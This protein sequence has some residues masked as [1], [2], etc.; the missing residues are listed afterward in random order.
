MMENQKR[1][2]STIQSTMAGTLWARAKYSKLYPDILSD[3]R[4]SELIEKVMKSYPDSEDEF[5]ILEEFIDELLGLAFIVRARTFDDAVREFIDG[6]PLASI[7]NLGC[8]L[9]TT[10]SRVDNGQIH[11]YDLDLPDAIEYRLGLIP[12]TDRSRCIPKSIFDYSWMQEVDFHEEEGLFMIAG[13]LFTYFEESNIS[14]LF[15]AMA[16]AF[17]GGEILFDSSSTRGNRI[18]NRRFKKFQVTGIDHKFNAKSPEQVENWSSLIM[19]K[20]WFPFFSRIEKNPNWKWRTRLMMR[21][22]SRFGLAKFIHVKFKVSS[23]TDSQ[24]IIQ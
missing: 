3:E 10:F 1:D 22:N 16:R 7:V 20:D 6:K 13:G 12:E 9:D 8:G 23:R 14:S 2:S 21:L 17:P 19:V 18:I 4:A 15:D 11:W 24:D 5:A